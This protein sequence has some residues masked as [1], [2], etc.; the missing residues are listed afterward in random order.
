MRRHLDSK[1]SKIPK[2]TSQAFP[3][4]A[5]LEWRGRGGRKDTHFTLFPLSVPCSY[6][7]QENCPQT[8]A[9][10]LTFMLSWSRK[11]RQQNSE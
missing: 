5:W 10:S 2:T 7:T 6:K 8:Q 9:T 1:M 11:C 3:E 4:L